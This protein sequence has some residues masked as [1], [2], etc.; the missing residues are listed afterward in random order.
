MKIQFD[1]AQAYQL[2]AIQAVVDV[3]DGQP[4]A[5]GQFEINMQAGSQLLSELGRGNACALDNNALLANAAEIQARND[6]LATPALLKRGFGAVDKGSPFLNFAL[7]METGT[8]K[9]YVYLRTI[10]ELHARYGFAKFVIVVP[11]VAIREGVKTSLALMREHFGALYGNQG[12]DYAVYDSKRVTMLRQFAQSNALQIMV[13]NIDAFNKAA[14]IMN[15]SDNDNLNGRKPIE[16]IQATQPI[17]IL[18]EPQNMESEANKASIASLNPLCTLRYSATHKTLYQLLYRLDPVRA[19]D[20]GLV[21]RIEVDSVLEEGDFNQ[22]FVR[23]ESITATKTKI[24]AKLTLHIRMAT[25]I[26]PRTVTVSSMGESLQELA[27]GHEVYADYVVEEISFAKQFIC[28][29]NGVQLDVGQSQGE[30]REEVMRA[31]VRQTIFKH[32]EKEREVSS[33]PD[34]QRVKV[35]SLFFLDKVANYYA[36][37][38]KIRRWFVE[39]YKE[40]AHNP[41]YAL[42]QLPPVE[43]VHNG[44]F[45]TTKGVAR[46]T[47]EGRN[48][49]ADDEAYKLIMQDKERLMDRATPLRF[50]FSHSALREGWDNPNVFQICTLNE[51]RSETRKRQEIGRGLRLPVD[52]TGQRV[53]NP[54]IARLTVVANESYHDFAQ[55][56]QN[57]IEEDTG[58]KFGKRITNARDRR[59]ANLIDDWQ[60]HEDFKTLWNLI[61]ARTRYRVEYDTVK[62][63]DQAADALRNQPAIHAP[64]IKTRSDQLILTRSG[65]QTQ[66][67]AS[68]ETRAHYILHVLP[69]MLGYLQRETR[70]T[71]GTLAQILIQSGRLPDAIVNAQQFLDCATRAIK[72][73]KHNLM[74]DGIKY[75]RIEGENGAWDMMLFEAKEIN[76]YADRMVETMKSLYDAI[77][78]DSQ[79]EI[80][81]ASGLE[82]RNEIK[83]F[84]KL[85]RWF[86]I[87]TPLGTYNPDW[88]VVKQ[89]LP[90]ETRLYLVRETKSTTNVFDIRPTEEGKITCGRA[91]FAALLGVDFAKVTDPADV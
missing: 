59:K 28:F 88:A 34:G 65:I 17:V 37:D 16:F 71:R 2:D 90:D 13:I 79:T 77:E 15:R 64:T 39:L 75:E 45:A 66:L 60:G 26:A 49:Q 35:L 56:L 53:R 1:S 63:I 67:N 4:L 42:L 51:T 22:P 25:G 41:R 74:V 44:Y 91:H 58:E 54:D 69:D 82:H 86:K 48:T 80:K 55:G 72:Y 52:E 43:D 8:G 68:R 30:H 10:Y 73:V 18:D 24:T 19:Y 11:S 76:G 38:G 3:F 5:Q 14:N 81:F 21:K 83:F 57:E 62:L 27:N 9:T 40:L 84:F 12:A 89:N 70:L 87:E 23:V 20:L 7:E 29:A 61:R 32:L 31:Q 46:D 50:I 47:A 36:L 78:C 85:P 6:I 33:L